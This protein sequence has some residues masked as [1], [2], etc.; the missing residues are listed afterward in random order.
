MSAIPTKGRS[1]LRELAWRRLLDPS[2]AAVERLEQSFFA[3]MF[4]AKWNVAK[5]L[6]AFRRQVGAQLGDSDE[7]SAT[8]QRIAG[9]LDIVEEQRLGPERGLPTEPTGDN[10]VNP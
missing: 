10:P 5:R 9:L 3:A 2:P 8:L 4:A 7:T 6:L 1:L